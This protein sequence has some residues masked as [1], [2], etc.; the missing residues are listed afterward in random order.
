MALPPFNG[1]VS[2]WALFQV[3]VRAGSRRAAGARVSDA[4]RSRGCRAHRRPRGRGVR[5]GDRNGHVG[6]AAFASRG[7]RGRIA[8]ADAGRDGPPR[9]RRASRSACFPAW[10]LRPCPRGRRRG[11]PG[12]AAR[13]R[14]SAELH[15]AGINGVMSPVV[16]A[17]GLLIG[18]TVVVSGWHG[19]SARPEFDVA[20]R[21]GVVV[22]CC[23]RREW[24][25]PRH[26][27]RSRCNESST[28]CCI[29]TTTS[30][31][32][33]PPS[34]AGTSTRSVST[35]RVVDGV[36]HGVYRPV[37][38]Y[39][40]AWGERARWLQNGSVHRYLGYG[41]VALLVV[42]VIAR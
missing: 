19:R 37:V 28:T 41:F 10:S 27:S 16:I 6:V 24:N 11:R 23:R 18:A 22:A 14:A 26:R 31:S 36:D 7:T 40:Q 25:T 9:A 42:L 5:Q 3:L 13:I 34:R 38:G 20:P 29:R 17:I 4:G 1:F 32:P 39:V 21:T 12:A 8:G 15:L 33:T 35:R 30:T 2:E